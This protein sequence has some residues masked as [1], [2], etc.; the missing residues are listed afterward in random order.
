MCS[1]VFKLHITFGYIN[2][3]MQQCEIFAL[4]FNCIAIDVLP[5]TT[6]MVRC[7]ERT[8]EEGG[9]DKLDALL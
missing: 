7:A 3:S 6:H 5:Y 2:F 9:G 8:K 1:T 4:S